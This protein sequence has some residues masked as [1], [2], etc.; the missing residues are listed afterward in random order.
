MEHLNDILTSGKLEEYV[1]GLLDE[2]SSKEVESYIQKYPEVK[3]HVTAL[4]LTMEKLAKDHKI[5]PHPRLKEQLTQEL[6]SKES[7]TSTS[8]MKPWFTWASL[9]ASLIFGVLFFNA[10][11]NNQK[12]NNELVLLKE[13]FQSKQLAFQSEAD[14]LF[15]L[16]HEATVPVQLTNTQSKADL[17]VYFNPVAQKSMVKINELPKLSSE[18]S[19]QLWA[20]VEGVMVNMGVFENKYAFI[21]VKYIENPESFNITIEPKGGSDHPN[22]KRLVASEKIKFI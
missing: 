22:V 9:G 7:M 16:R 3:K 6:F 20:D 12:L 18:E 11:N 1:L 17:L 14:L 8:I 5:M 21:P 2:K 19:Y 15:F 13:E 4:E 10:N